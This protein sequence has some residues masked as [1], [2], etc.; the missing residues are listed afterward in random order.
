M[1]IVKNPTIDK[2]SIPTE[3]HGGARY[4]LD[5][6]LI[7]LPLQSISCLLLP[8]SVQWRHRDIKNTKQRVSPIFFTSSCTIPCP[9]HPFCDAEIRKRFSPKSRDWNSSGLLYLPL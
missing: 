4:N 5:L 7:Y 9:S 2:A 6:Q 1:K 3:R 8:L